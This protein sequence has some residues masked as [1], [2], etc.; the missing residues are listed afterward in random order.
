MNYS[1]NIESTDTGIRIHRKSDIIF[2]IYKLTFPDNK[3]YIGQSRRPLAKRWI[4]G[5]KHNSDI[6]NAINK[7]GW[8]SIKKELISYAYDQ[9]EADYLETYFISKYKSTDPKYGYNKTIGGTHT[10]QTA[11]VCLRKSISHTGLKETIVTKKKKSNKVIAIKDDI[12]Y[13]CDS[14]KL[15]GDYLGTSKDYVKTCLRQP[16]LLYDYQVYY[17]DEDKRKQMINK[18]LN[19]QRIRKPK[20]VEI[21]NNLN[22]KGVETN[23]GYTIKYLIYS[24]NSDKGYEIVD[25]L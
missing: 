15:L 1:I 20:Y 2:K 25:S 24:D 17:Y 3:C 14:G 23:N 16:C 12:L 7:F 19:G 18:V 5:Y 11:E 4:G 21:A 13:I 6:S 10:K 8:N 22:I 9:T